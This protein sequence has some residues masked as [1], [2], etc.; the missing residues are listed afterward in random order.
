MEDYEWLLAQCIQLLLTRE[1]ISEYM[2]PDSLL[3]AGVDTQKSHLSRSVKDRHLE[4]VRKPLERRDPCSSLTDIFLHTVA[5]SKFCLKS[6]ITLIYGHQRPHFP[7][8]SWLE[9]PWYNHQL[10]NKVTN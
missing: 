9:I 4:T 3:W 1:Y 6:Q 2:A 5:G 8:S 7:S 10:C